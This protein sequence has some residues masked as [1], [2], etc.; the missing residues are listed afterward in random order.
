MRNGNEREVPCQ[1]RSQPRSVL[2]I[3]AGAAGLSCATHLLAAGVHVTVLEASARVGGRCLTVQNLNNIH[4]PCELGAT[5]LHGVEGNP[6]YALCNSLGLL[7][8]RRS[9]REHAPPLILRSDGVSGTTSIGAVQDVNRVMRDAVAEIENG[10]LDS[11]YDNFGDHVRA[12]WRTARPGLVARHGGDG[13]LLDA[14]W[15]AAEQFQCAV[16]GC[17]D[18]AEQSCGESYRVYEDF[19]GRNVASRP[20]LGGYSAA[21]ESLAQPLREKGALRLRCPV[22]AIRWCSSGDSSDNMNSGVHVLLEDDTSLWADAC[23]IA[24]PIVP[25]RRLRFEPPLPTINREAMACI[26]E[27]AVEKL[28]VAFEAEG[29]GGD[30]GGEVNGQVSGEL[31]GEVSGGDA[32]DDAVPGELP[33]LKLLWVD[34]KMGEVPPPDSTDAGAGGA[35]ESSKPTKLE[36]W[37]RGLQTLQRSGSEAEGALSQAGGGDGMGGANSAGTEDGS[38]GGGGARASLRQRRRRRTLVGWLTGD[39]ARA[40]SGRSSAELLPELSAGLAPFLSQLN[41]CTTKPGATATCTWRPVAVHATSWV[42]DA[43]IGGSYSFP[44]PGAPADVTQRL[45]TPLKTD[46]GTPVVLFAGEATSTAFGTVGGAL[47]SGEREARRLLRAWDGDGE[48][49]PIAEPSKAGRAEDSLLSVF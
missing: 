14:A 30:A 18:L 27:G 21:L 37:V 47:E 15:R 2:V 13:A 22:M 17:G 42:S 46:D 26:G 38:G 28:Y 34:E 10:E 48:A 41:D 9:K 19:D 35:T 3:G 25:L 23:C 45:A 6:A 20:E 29:E 16:D 40:V 11:P 43:H 32:G 8:P 24:I 12:A 5:Y 31:S 39:A 1:M 36:P 44:R 33:S 49:E 7:P 4:G